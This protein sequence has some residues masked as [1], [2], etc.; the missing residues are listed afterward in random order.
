MRGTP[1]AFVLVTLAITVPAFADGFGEA[2]QQPR[3]TNGR[4]AAQPGANLDATFRR[5]V[6][7]QTGP[8]W[9]GYSVP[10]VAASEGRMNRGDTYI[11]DGVV[12]TNGRLATCGLESTTNRRPSDQPVQVQN[13]VR[14]E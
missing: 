8:G 1:I 14:L 12:F 7:A 4:L 3:V 2:G 11:S 9:I 5:L 10:V 13:P 6:S